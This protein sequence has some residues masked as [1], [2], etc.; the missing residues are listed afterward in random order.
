M[1]EEQLNDQITPAA[2]PAPTTL[3]D[4]EIRAVRTNIQQAED[5]YFLSTILINGYDPPRDP[6]RFRNDRNLARQILMLVGC[7]DIVADADRVQFFNHHRTLRITYES[8]R[9]MNTAYQNMVSSCIQIR[10]NGSTPG[11]RFSKMIPYRCKEQKAAFTSYGMQLKREGAIRAF[12]LAMR[13]GNLKLYVTRR[14]GQREMVTPPNDEPMDQDQQAQQQQE[15]GNRDDNCTICLGSLQTGLIA[16]TVCSH[17]FHVRCIRTWNSGTGL[18]C[19]TCNTS[20]NIT[21][22]DLSCDHCLR[23]LDDNSDIRELRLSRKC[24]HLHLHGCQEEHLSTI[25]QRFPH[26]PDQYSQFLASMHPGCR[27]C[28]APQDNFVGRDYGAVLARRV[29]RG[30]NTTIRSYMPTGEVPDTETN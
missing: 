21:R 7:E 15:D 18:R 2:P 8:P 10:R 23:Q 13:D 12:E 22:A 5:N 24:G 6:R 17:V 11:L 28:A 4:Y 16:K 25:P 30:R 9:K 1:L 20:P 27:Q 3:S 14:N 26:V 19:P 29:I